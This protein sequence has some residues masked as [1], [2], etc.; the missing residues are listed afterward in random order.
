M[1][2]IGKMILSIP[3]GVTLNFNKETQTVQVNG[4]KGE[5]SLVVP[6]FI[7][8]IQ[9]ESHF[10]VKIEKELDKK[11][12][13]NWGTYR[14]LINNMIIG[15][16]DGFTRTMELNGVGYKMELA[17]QTLTLYIGYSHPVKVEVPTTVKLSLNKNILDGSSI[18]KHDLGDFFMKIHNMKPCDVYK[19]KGFKI[20]G[21][22]YRKKVG[23]KAK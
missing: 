18:S 20:P 11:Q 7:S 17:G 13:S 1:S 19:Q 8:I 3:A 6:S 9:E 5:L 21:R 14:A 16:S 22:F 10:L 12:R 15:V 2:R 4:P 23:K